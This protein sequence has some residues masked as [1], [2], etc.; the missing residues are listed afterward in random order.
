ME[1][2]MED[3]NMDLLSDPPYDEEYKNITSEEGFTSAI[4]TMTGPEREPKISGLTDH[5]PVTLAV[6]FHGPGPDE[7]K[8][9]E[10]TN[11]RY[12]DYKALKSVLSSLSWESVCGAADV[13]SATG[14]FIGVSSTCISDSTKSL[15]QGRNDL[16]RS[17][18]I[19]NGIINAV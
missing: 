12:V 7:R 4:N 19:T 16:K 11:H 9:D 10:R 6:G 18:W 3:T 5:Y 1:M 15:K 2:F 17:D 8:V 14:E 13:E